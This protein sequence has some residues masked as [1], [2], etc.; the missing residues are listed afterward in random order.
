M[1]PSIHKSSCLCV[2]LALA[3]LCTGCSNNTPAVPVPETSA[4]A[5]TAEQTVQKLKFSVVPSEDSGKIIR[6][7]ELGGKLDTSLVY[8]Q[9]S[10]VKIVWAGGDNFA[11]RGHP[12]GETVRAGTLCLCPAGCPERL[13]HRKLPVRKWVDPF[14][15][16]LPGVR[17]AA[18]L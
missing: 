1:K 5:E 18:G 15:L 4:P 13:L 12:G 8:G 14:S 10:E 16:H 3:L 7:E 2:L 11:G 6:E 9:L 17:V